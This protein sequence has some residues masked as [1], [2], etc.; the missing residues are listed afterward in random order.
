MYKH[1]YYFSQIIAKKST[2]LFIT[3]KLPND[4]IEYRK[5]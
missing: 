5:N 1:E 3:N 4:F 2:I